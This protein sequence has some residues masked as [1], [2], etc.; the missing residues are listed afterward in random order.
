MHPAVLASSAVLAAGF[1]LLPLAPDLAPAPLPAA[2]ALPAAPTTWSVDPV[3]STVLFRI[4]HLNAAWS[5]GR[6]DV[7]SGSVVLDREQPAASSIQFTVDAASINTGSKDRDDHLR[8]PDFFNAKVNPKISFQSTSVA[9]DG[10]DRFQVT[11]KLKL[12]G[13]EKQITVPAEFVG[14]GRNVQNQDVIGLEATFTI[15][16][17]EYG[18]K[19]YPGALGEDVK[20]TVSI[21]AVKQG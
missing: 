21:E 17:S 14:A 7:M 3:H 5:H 13:V 4:K 9:A 8:G 1:L 20:L 12:N 18:I 19:T 2:P 11:G 15:P 10:K 6:F 16:R